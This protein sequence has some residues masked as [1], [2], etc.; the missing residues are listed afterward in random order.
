[1][2]VSKDGTEPAGTHWNAVH[3]ACRSIPFLLKHRRFF[4]KLSPSCQKM[5]PYDMRFQHTN[6]IDFAWKWASSE[7]Q[8]TSSF[9]GVPVLLMP[10]SM[11]R[12]SS[13]FAFNLIT[14]YRWIQRRKSRVATRKSTFLRA[15]TSDSFK[16]WFKMTGSTSS[17]S[18]AVQNRSK[19]EAINTIYAKIFSTP[20][21]G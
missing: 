11:V 10:Q 2:A 13:V 16:N 6:K 4:V 17:K 21:S 3:F 20:P 18:L 9:G 7:V 1:M 5:A 14:F 8:N 12:R 15:P 19:F